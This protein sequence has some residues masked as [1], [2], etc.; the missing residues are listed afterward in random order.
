MNA[1]QVSNIAGMANGKLISGDIT[2]EVKRVVTDSRIAQPGD[3]FVA[4]KGPN[5]DAHTFIPEM[6]DR[7]VSAVMVDHEVVSNASIVKVK[8]TLI[9]L[10]TLAK[11]Y[12][13]LLKCHVVGITGSN[14]KTSTK[15]LTAAVFSS[16]FTV[17]KTEG[18]QNNHIGLP[19]SVLA[20]ED[21][22]DIAILE[23]GMNHAG[24]IAPLAEIAAPHV[25]I[26]TN[27]GTAHIEFLKTQQAI[28]EEKAELAR[29]IPAK[30]IVILNAN[31]P[32]TPVIAK[33]CTARILTAG[34]NVGDVCAKDLNA[35][36][37][38]TT[39]K[40]S[41]KL[42]EITAFLPIPGQHMVNNAVLALAAGLAHG[43]PLTA[44]VDALA[45]IQLTSARLETKEIGGIHFLDD[46]YNANPDSMQAALA[47]LKT[48]PGSGKKIAVLGAMGE[49]GD[50]S[51][52]G[53]RKVGAA[54]QFVDLLVT[55]GKTAEWIADEA[56]KC[57]ATQVIR[58]ADFAQAAAALLSLLQPGD[59]VLVKGSRSARMEQVIQELALS[60][61]PIS[62]ATTH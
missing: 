28:A 44:A 19:L 60:L 16:K 37:G 39:F 41:Y 36:T 52:E 4:L 35:E 24:E 25:A 26:I 58:T 11:N 49:L 2:T 43:I 23:I 48:V 61:L 56:E 7:P 18:N 20:I 8:D 51:E 46:T 33:L 27:I 6:N 22:H 29:A 54:T 38:G 40:V 53:H 14:G 30:G 42:E 31:D 45:K 13:K 10:Q 15:D 59:W 12:R 21:S 57:G 5:F 47:T 50:Y 34:I 3:L 1:I 62:P 55:V 17:S 9:G 32:F